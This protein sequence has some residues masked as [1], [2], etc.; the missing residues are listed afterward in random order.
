MIRDPGGTPICSPTN[1]TRVVRLILWSVLAASGPCLAVTVQSI[2]ADSAGLAETASESPDKS[3]PASASDDRMPVSGQVGTKE[4]DLQDRRVQGPAVDVPREVLD[5]LDQRKRYLDRREQAM[6][7]ELKRLEN[8]KADLEELLVRY[9]ASVQA[10]ETKQG[11]AQQTNQE[12]ENKTRDQQAAEAQ[13]KLGVVAKMYE[14]MPAEEAAARIEKM[15]SPM[16]VQ[17]LRTVKSKTAGAILA[18]V[19]PDKAAKL[20]EQIVN[21]P[22]SQPIPAASIKATR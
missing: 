13:A 14:G 9:E 3:P 18:Q 1:R 17:V 7:A 10:F 20:T 11:Q 6:R 21:A 22:A 2:G 16:A 4:S 15:P 12:R 8:L 19:R 5:L